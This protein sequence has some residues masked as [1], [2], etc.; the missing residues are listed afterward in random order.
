MTEYPI[1]IDLTPRHWN[2]VRLLP[3]SLSDKRTGF[4]YRPRPFFTWLQ[5]QRATR[6]RSSNW[7]DSKLV[8]LWPSSRQSGVEDHITVA[9]QDGYSNRFDHRW[10]YLNKRGIPFV[11][12]VFVV[13]LLKF[14]LDKI[15]FEFL[16]RCFVDASILLS[17]FS[18]DNYVW[19]GNFNLRFFFYVSKHMNFICI[20]KNI[21]NSLLVRL[22]IYMIT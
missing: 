7:S 15:V 16:A 6:D 10:C 1:S 12:F 9:W 11:I 8:H 22:S 18:F 21:Y 3:A 4:V 19:V 13:V 14:Q 2:W 5:A 17:T 20:G